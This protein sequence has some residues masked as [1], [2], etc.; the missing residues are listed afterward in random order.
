MVEQPVE[1]EVEEVGPS[2][3]N[4]E[5][6]PLVETVEPLEALPPVYTFNEYTSQEIA[7]TYI[8]VFSAIVATSCI[9]F[10]LLRA[11]RRR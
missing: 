4:T 10:L 6:N 3:D 11:I 5:N 1:V 8:A 9:I 2:L 7:S